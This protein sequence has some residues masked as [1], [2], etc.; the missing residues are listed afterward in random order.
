MQRGLWC[1]ADGAVQ[2]YVA[3]GN[4][5]GFYAQQDPSFPGTMEGRFLHSLLTACEAGDVAALD[6]AVADYDRTK[7]VSGYM[8]TL[9]RAV[10]KAVQDEPDLA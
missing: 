7:R 9:L 10:R 4:A 1:V 8:A 5:M 6:A 2:D 3:C